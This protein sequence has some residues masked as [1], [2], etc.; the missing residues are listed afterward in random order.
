MMAQ[1][2]VEILMAT[3]NGAT[4]IEEQIRSLQ[5]QTFADWRLLIHDDGSMD[6]TLEIIANYCKQDSRIL[7]LADGVTGL[8]A[9]A[10]FLHLLAHTDASIVMLCDQDDL[11]L[12]D[13]IETM[14]HRLNAMDGPALIYAN[15]HYLID[16]QV[17]PRQVTRQHP[18]ALPDFLFLNAGI[19]GCSMMMNRAL[20]DT[21]GTPP[22]TIAMHD[23]LLALCALCF[24][25]LQYV[26]AVLML[27]RQHGDNATVHHVN[28]W[29]QLKAWLFKAEG[30]VDWCHY[31]ANWAFYQHY[32]TQLNDMQRQV[33]K[34][35]FNF[36][37]SKSLLER[38]QI[39]RRNHFSLGGNQMVL[40]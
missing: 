7:V 21:L 25:Q 4:Y 29:K 38:M 39:I 9:A 40:F 13:K 17:I 28:R 31:G 11:W 15:A 18:T 2:K 24:G 27:Y 30:V 36:V 34:E 37:G 26:D 22:K 5:R 20:I 1:V 10:N 3:Y 14:L 23:H 8:G 32:Y 16:G 6:A 33:F 35:Y 19:Q 12:P